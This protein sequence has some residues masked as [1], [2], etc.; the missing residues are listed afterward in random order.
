MPPGPGPLGQG[1]PPSQA[2]L[3][4]GARLQLPAGHMHIG[5]ARWGPD[6]EPQVF[7]LAPWHDDSTS[8]AA[9]LVSS[10]HRQF[11]ENPPL[12]CFFLFFLF[13]FL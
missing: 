1:S 5:R 9:S 2:P 6:Q 3:L 11:V 7:D 12:Y 13:F 8:V 4:E 10:Q